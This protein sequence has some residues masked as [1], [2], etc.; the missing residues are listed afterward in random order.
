MMSRMP[1]FVDTPGWA[2]DIR[3]LLH[4]LDPRTPAGCAP[5]MD[6]IDR[7]D[8][9]EIRMDLPGVPAEAIA[10]TIRAG[11]LLV[12]GEKRPG[13]AC[14]SGA[15]FHV[16]ERVFGTFVRTVQLRGAFDARAVEAT[17]DQGELRIRVPRI[18]ERRGA[19]I[20]IPVEAR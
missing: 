1:S 6:V 3:R 20:R 17:L 14:C 19:E 12:T 5:P 2:E 4:D 16:A 18:E 11:T 9:L 15:A 8:G 7:A 10:V 13:P